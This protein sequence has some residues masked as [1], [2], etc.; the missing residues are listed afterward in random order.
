MYH[1]LR[2]SDLRL[3]MCTKE[4]LRNIKGCSLAFFDKRS[5][6]LCWQNTM[7]PATLTVQEMEVVAGRLGR[8]GLLNSVDA[9]HDVV[10][11]YFVHW[12]CCRIIEFVC[13]A[14]ATPAT[15]C[16]YRGFF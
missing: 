16:C 3:I 15:C 11:A 12:K 5:L 9:L 1:V 7:S 8:S 2:D 14:A 10:S 13:V 6:L 4:T